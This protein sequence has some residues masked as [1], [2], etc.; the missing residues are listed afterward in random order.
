M[1][2]LGSEFRE[3]VLRPFAA[4]RGQAVR[5]CEPAVVLVGQVRRAAR[6]ARRA[7]PGAVQN[8]TR[9]HGRRL[10]RQLQRD[11]SSLRHA[12]ERDS[13]ELQLPA[14]RTQ[15]TD[16]AS[17]RWVA[18]RE[19][20]TAP[21]EPDDA[22]GV[23]QC[24]SLRIPHLEIQRPTVDQDYRRPCAVI[25]IAQGGA[26]DLDVLVAKLRGCKFVQLSA[27][28]D[29]SFS[30]SE[31]DF[32]FRLRGCLRRRQVLAD[33]RPHSD[34]GAERQPR[35][36]GEVRGDPTAHLLQH[37]ETLTNQFA[38]GDAPRVA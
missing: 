14:Q 25:A 16:V 2:V 11:A 9:N 15:I 32:A 22:V 13:L 7:N 31:K 37:G 4:K 30:Y 18:G 24:R 26:V 29:H 36:A 6:A 28:L 27:A 23:R 19:P 34:V 17:Q 38:L 12:E 10:A 21:I 1:H 5:L 8:E 20:E 3:G 33:Q 35:Y